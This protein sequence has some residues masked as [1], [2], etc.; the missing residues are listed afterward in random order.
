VTG[1]RGNSQRIQQV[2]F[3]LGTY[4]N[5]PRSQPIARDDVPVVVPDEFGN[6]AIM[7]NVIDILGRRQDL[8]FVPEE[9]QTAR[10]EHCFAMVFQA[11][12][13]DD[14]MQQNIRTPPEFEEHEVWHG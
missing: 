3:P 8:H 2:S 9:A 13:R 12:R 7:Q 11:A 4:H 1:P 6:A 10:T 14:Q 5:V